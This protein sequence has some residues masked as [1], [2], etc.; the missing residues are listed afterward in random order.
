[1]SIRTLLK[2][3]ASN[4][5]SRNLEDPPENEYT[6]SASEESTANQPEM[7]RIINTGLQQA[8]HVQDRKTLWQKGCRHK[9]V[10][11]R[12]YIWT[13]SKTAPKSAAPVE[14]LY[15]TWR[16]ALIY[17]AGQRS[18]S[19]DRSCKTTAQELEMTGF[20]AC[21]CRLTCRD[22]KKQQVDNRS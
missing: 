22:I 2:A 6:V 4:A 14:Q 5:G 7:W 8:A 19:Q 12:A 17:S 11:E 1:M 18:I 13:Y 3:E 20:C 21:S 10:R 16:P 15:S 9:Q